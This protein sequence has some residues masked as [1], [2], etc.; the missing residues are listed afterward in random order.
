MT[1]TNPDFEGGEWDTDDARAE[2]VADDRCVWCK[3]PREEWA[4]DVGAHE[5]GT[6]EVICS[7]CLSDS[8]QYK[9]KSI[10]D[11]YYPGHWLADDTLEEM[12][13]HIDKVY[14][15]ATGRGSDG[16]RKSGATGYEVIDDE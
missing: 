8:R 9:R 5:I 4:D 14:E 16:T 15:A 1:D 11:I 12:D 13:E 6:G 10:V 7:N 2:P 3:W